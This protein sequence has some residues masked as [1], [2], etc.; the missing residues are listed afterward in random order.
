MEE[1]GGF[2]LVATWRKRRGPS[3]DVECGG[4]GEVRPATKARSQRVWAAHHTSRGRNR[5]LTGGP[6][7]AEKQNQFKI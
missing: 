4:G 1:G 6:R 7:S 5:A 3:D 2:G